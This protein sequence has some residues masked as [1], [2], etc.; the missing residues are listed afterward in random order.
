MSVTCIN[1]L[2][3]TS[4][5]KT[6]TKVLQSLCNFATCMMRKTP[7]RFVSFLFLLHHSGLIQLFHTAL[8]HLLMHPLEPFTLPYIFLAADSL[9][10][11]YALF[12]TLF[13]ISLCFWIII[14][15]CSI[16]MYR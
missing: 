13:L 6:N 15:L 11:R 8:F 14:Y 7:E 5:E 16:W 1:R 10:S 9:L 12:M 4:L 3:F 2:T